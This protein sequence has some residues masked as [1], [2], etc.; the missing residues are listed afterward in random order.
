MAL[1]KH[2]I[3]ALNWKI[4]IAADEAA[5]D[6]NTPEDQQ[7]WQESA[8]DMEAAIADDTLTGH[9]DAQNQLINYLEGDRAPAERKA[10]IVDLA[11]GGALEKFNSNAFY[12]RRPQTV[13]VDGIVWEKP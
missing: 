3:E 13:T 12:S 11:R 2:T 8:D 4:D 7:G 6:H 1:S 10:I 9:K 5:A